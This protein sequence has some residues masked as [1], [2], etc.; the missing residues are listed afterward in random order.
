M[1]HFNMFKAMVE[2]Q[3]DRFIKILKIDNGGEYIRIDFDSF[4]KQNGINQQ[5]TMSYTPKQNG[6]PNKKN[7]VLVEIA[8][9]TYGHVH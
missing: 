8:R 3:G 9:W 2:G 6:V 1:K 7:K 5:S 4:H